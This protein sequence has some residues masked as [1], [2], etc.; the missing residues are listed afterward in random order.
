LPP[1]RSDNEK[2]KLYVNITALDVQVRYGT[3][4]YKGSSKHKQNPHLFGLEPFRGRRGD[5]TL[6]DKHAGFSP[7]D[8]VRVPLLL[9]RAL[10]AR[11][12]GSHMWTVDDNGWI[13]ELAVT[14]P[15]SNEHH[16]YPLRP[17]EAIAETV[18]RHFQS[19]ALENGS[20]NDKA[21]ASACRER[22]GFRS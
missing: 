20:E 7:E 15:T 18:F 17:S 21:A 1:R 8:M 14:N 9:Q 11:L 22:Y 2:R 3:V 16:G 6:C 13:Y 5:R 12:V 19:W 4:S 10:C